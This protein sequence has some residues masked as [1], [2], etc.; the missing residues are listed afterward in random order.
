LPSRIKNP[1]TR[2]SGYCVS[3]RIRMEFLEDV[4]K[5]KEQSKKRNFS[6][7]WDLA[8]GLKN[9]DLKN[10]ENK[11][12]LDFPLPEGRGKEVKTC[13]IVDSMLAEAKQKANFT[14]TKTDLDKLAKDKKKLKKIVEENDMWFA[15][16]PLMPLIGKTLG[17][18]L[19]PAG[20]MPR[21]IPPKGS[22]E[23]FIAMSKK[24]I[25][26]RIKN[27]PVIH[28]SVGTEK[29]T[30]EQIAKNLTATINFIKE[31]LPKG[32]NNIQSVY[33]KLTMG[34]PV[35]VKDW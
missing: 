31:K 8:I 34:K 19:G 7:S 14:I 18:V 23:P 33:L 26:I 21:P 5:A 6:Q 2:V 24:M 25:K 4:K 28:L 10:P 35:K 17:I 22:I 30:D 15:E 3:R 12:N 29:M 16:A 11:L 20:K 13:F 32:R 27:N 1:T 9:I